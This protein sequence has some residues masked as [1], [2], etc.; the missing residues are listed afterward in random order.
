MGARSATRL[1]RALFAL[2]LGALVYAGYRSLL[3]TPFTIGWLADRQGLYALLH[4][5]EGM[6]DVGFIDGTL[7]DWHSD[8]LS[9]ITLAERDAG[10]LRDARFLAELAGFDPAALSPQDR[11]TYEVLADTRR[12]ALGF[13]RFGWLSAAGLYPLGPMDGVEVWLPSFLQ[14]SH[15]VRNARSARH[16]VARLR[17]F[18]PALD[19]AVAAMQW[20]REQGVVM[21]LALVDR[22]L[23]V[24]HDTVAAKPAEHALVTGF[25]HR[26]AEVKDLDE[27]ERRALI[28]AAA[29]AMTRIVYPAYARVAAALAASRPAAAARGAGVGDLPDGAAYYAAL[30]REMTTTDYTPAEARDLGLFEVAR[31]SAE[32]DQLLSAQGLREGTVGERMTALAHDPRYV[33]PNTDEGRALV[34]ARYQAILDEINVQMPNYFRDPPNSRLEV[35]RVP[36]E[37]QAAGPGAYYMPPA[38]DGSRPGVFFVNLR[39]VA[40]SPIW[41][42]NTLAYHEGIPGHHFQGAV[43]QRQGDLPWFRRLAWYPAYGEGWALY[44]ERLAAEMGAY[45]KDPL[46]DLGRLQ[47]ELMRAVR[48]VVDTGLHAEGWSRE[49][50]ID[51]MTSTTGLPRADVTSEVERYM[52]TP[53]QACA[54]KIGQLKILALREKARAALGARFDLKDFHT[55]VLAHGALPLTL[56]ERQVDAYIASQRAQGVATH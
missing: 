23:E 50:A 36:P 5:P 47:A 6:T 43:A 54:Y 2:L 26:L 15:V 27:D 29:D 14:S 19:Q 10:Y 33:L 21:P 56:L 17:A 28:S 38:L 53:G 22:A 31:I 46:A 51:Y 55:V 4:D 52:E 25:A 45:A 24:T 44:A 41:A 7:L 35:Q 20:Q 37:Q 1:R 16:Y 8:R 42:M 30:L 32:M 18:G 39:N 34:L 3:G 49:R 12:T 13:Q 40:S 9:P 11:I 48:L